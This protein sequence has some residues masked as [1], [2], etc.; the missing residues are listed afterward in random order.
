MKG[1]SLGGPG[2][3][4]PCLSLVLPV[5]SLELALVQRRDGA[6]SCLTTLR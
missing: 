2:I 4:S 6:R 3:P 5:S 1:V